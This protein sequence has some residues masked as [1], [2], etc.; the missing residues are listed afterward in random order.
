VLD[1]RNI[2]SEGPEEALSKLEAALA[3]SL[4]PGCQGRVELATK[5]L[6]T[7]TGFQMAF[8]DTF[9]SFTTSTGHPWLARAQATLASAL[10]RAVEVDV[11]RFATDGGHFAAAGTTVLG[12]GPG[13]DTLVHTVEERIPIEDLV[14]NAVGCVAL[15][16]DKG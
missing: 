15:A 14:E 16:L 9:P 4:E 6:S 5:N 2:P 1:W 7:Y 12:F 10:G 13:D 8:P 3:R 11:W